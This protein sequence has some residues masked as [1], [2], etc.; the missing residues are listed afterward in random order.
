MNKI[1]ELWMKVKSYIPDIQIVNLQNFRIGY[2]SLIIFVAFLSYVLTKPDV[3]QII[4]VREFKTFQENGKTVCVK[5]YSRSDM[6][7]V[8]FG[9]YCSIQDSKTIKI[10][11]TYEKKPDLFLK[12]LGPSFFL[13]IGILYLNAGLRQEEIDE[14]QTP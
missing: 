11:Q 14:E 12:Y 7:G 13:F 5:L 8:L 1:S 2:I 4:T 6:S 10:G 3:K 9:E